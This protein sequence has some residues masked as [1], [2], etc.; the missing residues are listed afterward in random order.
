M[1]IKPINSTDQDTSR[2]EVRLKGPGVTTIGLYDSAGRALLTK[3]LALSGPSEIQARSRLPLTLRTKAAQVPVVPVLLHQ[4]NPTQAITFAGQDPATATAER[5]RAMKLSK[6]SVGKI[7][8][9]ARLAAGRD[10]SR[11]LPM[12]HH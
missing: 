5:C 3:R 11:P 1:S 6:A 10:N 8:A 2:I 12:D 4:T 9:A 7:Q